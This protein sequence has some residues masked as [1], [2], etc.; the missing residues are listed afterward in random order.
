MQFFNDGIELRIEDVLAADHQ[1]FLNVL[2]VLHTVGDILERG[3]VEGNGEFIVD[4]AAVALGGADV[5]AVGINL[6][7]YQKRF[8]FVPVSHVAQFVA[9]G[10][11]HG[12]RIV[13]DAQACRKE[14]LGHVVHE[15]S[16]DGVLFFVALWFFEEL[17]ADAV[18][19]YV[20]GLQMFAKLPGEV[21]FAG[22]REAIQH[23][24]QRFRGDNLRHMYIVYT[25]F[26]PL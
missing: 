2:G 1:V 18:A 6:E 15:L 8:G 13:D 10:I 12:I 24:Q 22:S 4:L 20:G 23:N 7:P 21:R 14:F 19:L 5:G 25:T 9:L 16:N 3:F 11:T 17:G 26:Y